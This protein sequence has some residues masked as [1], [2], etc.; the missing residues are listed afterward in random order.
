MAVFEIQGPDG[1]VYEVEAPDEQAALR[2]MGSVLA[3]PAA[4]SGQGTLNNVA[5]Q[6]GSGVFFGF[7]DEI[8]ARLNAMTGYDAATG[9]YGNST[10]YADQLAAVR[11]Q[12]RQFEADHPV[13]ATAA[14][15]G[16]ALATVALP[17]GVATRGGGLLGRM[18]TG[19]LAGGAQSA[20]YGFGSAEGGLAPRLEN[21]GWAATFGGALGAAAPV[22]GAAVGNA[23]KGRAAR[24][25]VQQAAKD[26]PSSEELRSLGNAL[27]KQI[28][29]AGV[30]IKPEAFSSTR[31][32]LTEALRTRT[33]FDELPGPGSLTPN[34]A[35]VMQIM[36]AAD[37]TLAATPTAALP[38]RSLDQMRRQA[39]A[40]AGNVAN[41][42]DQQAGRVVIE[43][44]DDFVQRLRPE[45]VVGGDVEALKTA[46][47]KAREVW[48]RMSKSQLVDDAIGRADN[49]LSGS[50]SGLRNQFKNILQNKKLAAQFTDAEKAA[51]RMV[52]HG[53][54]LD[55]MVNLAGGG[56]AQMGSIGGGLAVGGPLGG[57]AGAGLAAGQRKL[58]EAL[59][60]RRA[61]TARA[62][63]ASGA[64][65]S[66][67]ALAQIAKAGEGPQRLIEALY[68][69]GLRPTASAL[70]EA[71]R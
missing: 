58:A 45:D 21:A 33:G 69:A 37:N 70:A 5:Q 23:V 57:L 41:K 30:Q 52:T 42:T 66:P 68:M 3:P 47:P 44:L 40:A 54:T 27:Y 62:A 59:V 19:A 15:L 4:P 50:A 6:A 20:I 46:I 29:D 32:A 17:M 56:L 71:L 26:A 12:E 60:G 24:K 8:S 55:Q 1:S 67:E 51:L 2:A 64:L 36:E 16:G 35:R 43:Q 53:S 48:S 38:F 11:G 14:E 39:G 49:Y 61:E 63:I 22:V 34:T 31:E 9:T 13:A 7:G 18:G 28:D 65:R 10:T 25:A